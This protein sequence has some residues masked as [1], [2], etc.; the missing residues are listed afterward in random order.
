MKVF[1][2]GYFFL[3]SSIDLIAKTVGVSP[4]T[5]S[6][7]FNRR[8][9][10]SASLTR[11]VLDAARRLNYRPPVVARRKTLSLVV[12][13]NNLSNNSYALS[14]L[15]SF[16]YTASSFDYQV[17]LV[18]LDDLDQIYLNFSQAVIAMVYSE[19]E[20]DLLRSIENIPVVTI[21]YQTS[22]CHYVCSDHFSGAYK[23]VEYL[24]SFGHKRIGILLSPK[25]ENMSWGELARVEGYRKAMTDN[26]CQIEEDFFF[27]GTF[28][29]LSELDLFLEKT[30]VTSLFICGEN[31]VLP[32][33]QKLTQLNYKIPDDLSIVTYYNP[34]VS[35]YL[36]PEPCCLV[37]NFDL[38]TEKT[39]NGLQKLKKG[40]I[41]EIK[42]ITKHD[43]L[44]GKSIAKIK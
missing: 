17:E 20:A 41:D 27:Y 31:M 4:A 13:R 18:Q 32:I 42:I 22:G 34:S 1:H 33:W 21:N 16:F 37:Q 30:S 6:R 24:H 38:I 28:S 14:M 8:P 29:R 15:G 39:L 3:M 23:A 10:V 7:V 43:F 44:P 26:N 5:V 25:Q 12:S 19:T 40:K 36:L 11:R 2:M 9:Y 35:P